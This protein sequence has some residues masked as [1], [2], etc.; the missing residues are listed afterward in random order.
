MLLM[1]LYMLLQRESYL[2]A[3]EVLEGQSCQD[4]KVGQFPKGTFKCLLHDCCILTS[5][6]CKLCLGNLLS[7]SADPLCD[8]LDVGT[9]HYTAIL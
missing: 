6:A 1:R 4:F 2:L 7:I 5:Q 3:L 8:G 9:V